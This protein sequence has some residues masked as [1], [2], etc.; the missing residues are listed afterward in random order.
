MI[1]MNKMLTCG[2]NGIHKIITCLCSLLDNIH[3]QLIFPVKQYPDVTNSS[4]PLLLHRGSCIG[5]QR[6]RI[7]LLA[8]LI[9]FIP[10]F[11]VTALKMF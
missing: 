10:R 11:D 9:H 4:G 8:I 2:V 3:Y 1:H 6:M 7:L 5:S